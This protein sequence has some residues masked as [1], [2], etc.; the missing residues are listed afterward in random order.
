MKNSTQTA[1]ILK[2]L[3]LELKALLKKDLKN[4]KSAQSKNNQHAG[5][6]LMAA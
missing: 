4:F 6:Q 5:K 3:D 1:V 2:S